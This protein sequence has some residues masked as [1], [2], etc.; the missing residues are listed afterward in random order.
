VGGPNTLRGYDYYEFTGTRVTLLNSELRVPFVDHLKLAF[1]LPIEVKGIKG[2]MFL[3]MG[4]AWFENEKFQ[5]FKR[6][7]YLFKLKDLKGGVGVGIRIGLGFVNI[8]FD[9]ARRTDLYNL[10][11]GWR[12]YLTVGRDF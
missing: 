11:P 7:G 5:P 10:F 2:V 8:K 9:A 6:G 4:N 3:D 1:P 12:Y